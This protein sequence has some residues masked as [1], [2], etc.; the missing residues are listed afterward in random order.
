MSCQDFNQ[1]GT[2]CRTVTVLEPDNTVL[3]S[4]SSG[5]TDLSL[6]ESGSVPIPPHLHTIAVPF[7]VLKASDDYSFE[8]L[9]VDALG[10]PNPG[11]I[12]PIV[13]YKI[14]GGFL[15]HLAGVPAIEGYV[16]RWRVVVNSLLSTG[17]QVNAPENI[18]QQLGTGFR[19]AVINFVNPR[20]DTNYGFTELR[21]ENLI[22]LPNTQ[23]LILPQVVAK[24]VSNFTVELST[25][26]PN[27][28][29][30]L[31]ARTP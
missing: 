8:Y 27:H 11:T 2:S 31:V 6:Q 3:S 26:P 28:N 14:T 16:L 18:R 13:D 22:D 24:S 17:I 12:V 19:V 5:S 4:T 21:I 25:P 29:Y 10:I 15:V 23:H 7:T 9:Y 20:S 1:N 30:F